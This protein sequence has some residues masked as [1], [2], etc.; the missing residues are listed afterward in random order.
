MKVVRFARP[1]ARESRVGV[2]SGAGVL[3]FSAAYR[4]YRLA[5]DGC[6]APLFSDPLELLRAGLFAPQV[7]AAALEFVEAHQMREMFTIADATLLAPLARPPKIIA[8]GRN[9]RAHALESG[10][11]VPDEPIFFCK[12]S[13]AVIGPEQPVVIK[14][15][16][17]RVDPEV[18]LAVIIGERGADIP[19]DRAPSFVAGYTVLNDVTARDMQKQ[20]LAKSNPW[21]RSK[22][23][24][25]FCPLGP[26]ITLPDE[27]QEP[28]ELNLEM[29]VN[30]EVRQRDNTGSLMFKV[31]YLIHF[32]SHFMTLEPGDIISTGT[33][34]GMA[35]IK[36][37]DVMEAEVEKIGILRNPVTAEA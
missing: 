15:D 4:V 29:R 2:L 11:G 34:E 36:P 3:D 17:T 16:L 24:D 21:F 13:T 20:D 35:P 1:G 7:F 6:E 18:E 33:P 31:P 37:G 25:T 28:V 8:L 14:R 9:Y 5:T 22:G 30:G 23:I 19:L 27:I 26:C 10:L 32:I 12:A